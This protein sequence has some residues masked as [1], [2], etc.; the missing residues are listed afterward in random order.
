MHLSKEKQD[1]IKEIKKK[2][3][4]LSIDF[5]DFINKENTVLEFT[6]EELGEAE[7]D[8]CKMQHIEDRI[9]FKTPCREVQI[10]IC[11]SRI[12]QRDKAREGYM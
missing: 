3:S 12:I 5:N 10:I 11:S 6:Q 9:D 1:Q 7:T 8:G 4:D 2:M